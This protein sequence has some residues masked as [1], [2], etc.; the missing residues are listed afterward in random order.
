MVSDTMS[1]SRVPWGSLDSEALWHGVRDIAANLV[2]LQSI[3]STHA[4][5]LRLIESLD[6]DE[7]IELDGTVIVAVEQSAGQGRHGRTWRSPPGGLYLTWLQSG[8]APTTI[9]TLPIVSAV[10]GL[11]ALEALGVTTARIKWPNDL[12][13]ADH[14][15]G[16]CLAYARSGTPVWS[17]VSIG[18]NLAATP[19]VDDRPL[20]PPT[21]VAAQVPAAELTL[22]AA[23]EA[24]CQQLHAALADIP[25]TVRRWQDN[26]LHAEGDR[27]TVRQASGAML[28]GTFVGTTAAGLLRLQVDGRTQEL[29][30]GDLVELQPA[31]TVSPEGG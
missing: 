31:E 4:L 17:A 27:V 25:A 15:V 19:P 1:T 7:D 8:L 30:A 14:K 20:H 6:D 3:D 13:I 9:P 16:G 21:S 5:A 29:A 22:P 12:I 18:I 10:A 28:R 11:G 2:L 24:Y 23:V 26:L